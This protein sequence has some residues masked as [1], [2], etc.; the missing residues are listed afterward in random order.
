MAV[1]PRAPPTNGRHYNQPGRISGPWPWPPTRRGRGRWRP[2]TARGSGRRPA[3]IV[4]TAGRGSRR[5]RGRRLHWPSAQSAVAVAPQP[6]PPAQSA[7]R[8]RGRGLREATDLRAPH[9]HHIFAALPRPAQSPACSSF[10]RP[11]TSVS[12]R[13]RLFPLPP[14]FPHHPSSL[15]KEAGEG[16]K[17]A[18]PVHPGL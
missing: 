5:G 1:T 2:K 18:P 7:E 15:L 4:T 12:L 6:W 17:G 14:P 11:C 16:A 13:L 9:R 3:G 10:V 8:V